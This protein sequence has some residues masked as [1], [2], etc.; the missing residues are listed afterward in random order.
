[1][2]APRVGSRVRLAV[3]RCICRWHPFLNEAS[4]LSAASFDYGDR[5][6][7]WSLIS[8]LQQGV[9]DGC[10]I[11]EDTDAQDHNDVLEPTPS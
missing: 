9:Y 3:R 4:A 5:T 11:G 2:R 7:V 6:G 8:G 1:M 10:G